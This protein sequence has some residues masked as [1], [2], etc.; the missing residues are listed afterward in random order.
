[1]LLVLL[2]PI[3]ISCAQHFMVSFLFYGGSDD[4]S[5]SSIGSTIIIG[6]DAFN[7]DSMSSSLFSGPRILKPSEVSPSH[8]LNLFPPDDNDDKVEGETTLFNNEQEVLTSPIAAKLAPRNRRQ[9]IRNFFRR[10]FNNTITRKL[11]I[12]PF[13]RKEASSETKNT[14]NNNDDAII[15]Q[16]PAHV[17]VA[18]VEM[19]NL[20]STSTFIDP[21]PT[22]PATATSKDLYRTTDLEQWNGKWN[23]IISDAFMN[24]YDTY[25]KQLGQPLVVRSIAKSIIGA[26]TEQTSII[27]SSSLDDDV[28]IA[29]SLLIRSI[30]ARGIWE[31]TLIASD[32]IEINATSIE[33]TDSHSIVNI[34]SNYT[35]PKN[36]V[37]TT[38]VTADNESVTAEAW[39]MVVVNHNDTSKN[40]STVYHH[41]W[42][43]GVTKYGGGDFESIRYLEQPPSDIKNAI[44]NDDNQYP[45]SSNVLVCHSI[46]HPSNPQLRET[47]RV[48]WRFGRIE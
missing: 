20:Q 45:T 24:E 29:P 47:A 21:D 5:G 7:I 6:T 44:V 3:V 17:L 23:I 9:Q 37:Y 16:P 34:L 12:Q 11:L 39:W 35:Y 28:D 19:R 1:M 40:I 43:R 2:L 15:E 42:L 26:T 36:P 31:R 14:Y 18:E 32:I 13:A 10:F 30:N 22:L 41:S 38:V 33:F 48:T 4:S 27:S 8:H 46:F 25:L